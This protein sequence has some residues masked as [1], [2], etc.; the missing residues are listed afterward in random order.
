MAIISYKFSL[1]VLLEQKLRRNGSSGGRESRHSRRCTLQLYRN[2][3]GQ[4]SRR[5]RGRGREKGM[6]KLIIKFSSL[7]EPESSQPNPNLL[8]K[9][10]SLSVKSL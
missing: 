10:A 1:G 9:A 5:G 2:V 6:I 7:L 3:Q 8:F 4:R